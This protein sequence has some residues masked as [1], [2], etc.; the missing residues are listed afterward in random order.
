MW[1]AVI[2]MFIATIFIS[3]GDGLLSKGLR[4]LDKMEWKGSFLQNTIGRISTAVKNPIIFLGVV[5][6]ATFFFMLLV[7]FSLADVSIV[8]PVSAFSYVFVALI[9][10]F[11]LQEDVNYLRWVGSL[12]IT[13]GV[14][15]VLM[16]E[17]KKPEEKNIPSSPQ[18]IEKKADA[19]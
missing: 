8:F 5:C 19:N 14:F 10:K 11:Y 1:K 17:G 13:G 15:I 9:A 7:A 2:T 3:I 16:G 6:H 18:C 12:I 4:E